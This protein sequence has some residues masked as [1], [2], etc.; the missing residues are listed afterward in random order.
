MPKKTTARQSKVKKEMDARTPNYKQKSQF[1]VVK[2]SKPKGI[3]PKEIFEGYK[4]K[5]SGS[6]TKTKKSKY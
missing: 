1:D 4:D 2:E 3:R 5:R 6:E